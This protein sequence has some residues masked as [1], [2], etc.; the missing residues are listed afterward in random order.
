MFGP[1]VGTLFKKKV[2]IGIQCFILVPKFCILVTSKGNQNFLMQIPCFKENIHQ[3]LPKRMMLR[4][5]CTL[6]LTF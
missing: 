2:S 3:F 6:Q 4:Q 5:F 1:C